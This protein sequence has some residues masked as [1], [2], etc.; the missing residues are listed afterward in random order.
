MG[1]F[2]EYLNSKGKL[3]KPKVDVSGG[4]PDP[5]TPPTK[6]PKEHGD[7]PYVAADGDTKR[8]RKKGKGLG[9]EG[10][11]DLKYKPSDDPKSKGHPPAHIPT[12]EQVEIATFIAEAVDKDPRLIEQLVTE[13]KMSGSLG[14][15]VAEILQHRASYEYMAEIMSHKEYGPETCNKLA[16]ALNDHKVVTEEVAPPFADQVDLKTK[17]DE[18]EELEDEVPNEDAA[19]EEGIDDEV[20]PSPQ[21]LGNNLDVDMAG[22]APE[23]NQDIAPMAG[24]P[25]APQ[26]AAQPLMSPQPNAMQNLMRALM[27]KHQRKY[28]Q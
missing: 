1:V 20:P 6:P 5:K 27:V 7:K 13:L 9:D 15:L 18:E 4:D 21:D 3:D 8:K 26:P 24:P 2:Q 12:V 16:R 11:E 28:M 17:A 22:E 14:L 25:M 23:L 10:D 19:A